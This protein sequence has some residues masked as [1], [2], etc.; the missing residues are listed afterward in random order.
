VEIADVVGLELL[1][2]FT[3]DLGQP[4][5]AVALQTAMATVAGL[6]VAN[7]SYNQPMLGLMEASL[8]RSMTG[9]VPTMTQRL[10][11]SPSDKR[12]YYLGR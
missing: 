7:I 4:R 11:E 10:V 8:P 6:A 3:V 12:Y 9:Q 1:R 5:D 2:L